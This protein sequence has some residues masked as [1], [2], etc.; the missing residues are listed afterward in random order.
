MRTVSLFLASYRPCSRP[1][2][3]TTQ[4]HPQTPPPG[5]GF[6]RPTASGILP[7]RPGIFVPEAGRCCCAA[8]PTIP[9]HPQGTGERVPPTRCA[10][11]LL[12]SLRDSEAFGPASLLSPAVKCKWLSRSG[13]RNFTWCILTRVILH[14]HLLINNFHLTSHLHSFLLSS[15]LLEG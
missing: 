14:N 4:T 10:L 11:P 2:G 1:P 5:R 15:G 12:S 3:A 6:S 9:L 8:A 13:L 7:L